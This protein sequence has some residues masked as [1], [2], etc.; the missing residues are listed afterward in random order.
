MTETNSAASTPNPHRANN[1]DAEEVYYEGSPL[2]RAELGRL[3]GYI[4]LAALP[5]AAVIA[6]RVYHHS[7]PIWWLV[8]AAIVIAIG[9]VA[10]PVL[11]ARTI[12]YRITNYRIDISTGALTSNVDTLELWHVEDL[13]MHQSLLNRLLRCGAITII[14]HDDTTPTLVLRGVPEPRRLFTLLEQ[15]VIAVKRQRG[16]LKM[17]SGT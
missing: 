9:L 12:R 8:L 1:D 2:L 16:V 10:W 6:W 3:L 4:F 11:V 7:F 14:S 17:D 5:I 13:H 15:R